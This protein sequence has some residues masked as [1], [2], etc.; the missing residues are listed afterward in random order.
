M[1]L[2]PLAPQDAQTSGPDGAES[3]APAAAGPALRLPPGAV[4][5]SSGLPGRGPRPP[6]PGCG[7][8]VGEHLTHQGAGSPPGCSPP[9][10]GGPSAVPASAAATRAGRP[11][12]ARLR[13][14]TARG[15]HGSA[16][17]HGAGPAAAG[18]AAA[19][20]AAE[21]GGGCPRARPFAAAA[22]VRDPRGGAGAGA[23]RGGARGEQPRTRRSLGTPARWGLGARG[24]AEE[25]LLAGLFAEGAPT[26]PLLRAPPSRLPWSRSG[27]SGTPQ[28]EDLATGRPGGA[29]GRRPPEGCGDASRGPRRRVGALL[30]PQDRVAEGPLASFP[31][32]LRGAK[33]KRRLES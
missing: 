22:G 12:G 8:G 17:G 28:T 31:P 32:A 10:A 18:A 1:D 13:P 21:A 24:P 33:R 3:L 16:R 15:S 5:P 19:A 7:K 29:P 9:P 30:R 2:Q 26:P 11:S 23:C 4:S 14:P 20:A 25:P 27:A 6:G